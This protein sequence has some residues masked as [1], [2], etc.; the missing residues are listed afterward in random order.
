M[1]SIT[2]NGPVVATDT[3]NT[4]LRE[5]LFHSP[6]ARE[7]SSTDYHVIEI[8]VREGA[9]TT[10][11][12]TWD[13]SGNKVNAASPLSILDEDRKGLRLKAGQAVVVKVTSTGTPASLEG[14]RITFTVALVGGRDGEAKPLVA[15][16]ATVADPNTRVSLAALEKQIN[17]GGLAEWDEPVQLQDPIALV[18]AGVFNGR[19]QRD[20]A[21]Q[22]SL[23]RYG[24]GWIDIDGSPVAIPSA[25][26]PCLSTAGLISNGGTPT[27]TQPSSSTLYYVYVGSVEDGATQLRLCATAP[28]T[29]LGAYYL[30]ASEAGRRWRFVG[31]V[32]TNSSTQF[33]DT[34]TDRLVVNYYNRLWKTILLRPAYSDGNTVTTYTTTST[35]WTAANAGT[36]ATASYIAN[37]EDGILIT[38]FSKCKSSGAAFTR[39]GIGDNSG[40]NCA[41]AGEMFGTTDQSTSCTFS[42]VPAAGYRTIVLLV[43]VSAGTGTYFADQTRDGSATDPVKT[44]LYTLVP[45]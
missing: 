42:S 28:T 19:I 5:A 26:F 12:G 18:V 15:S 2:I 9:Y 6:L 44:G 22:I 30:G 31:W 10:W 3:H 27:A 41:S 37:G 36:G 38:A 24:G 40:S 13:Q 21:T 35:T 23:Q 11:I 33:V 29:Y 39:I 1:A 17:T 45:V 8:G 16:G 14:S 25:G 32:R 7:V 4:V 20:S 43:C 34:T